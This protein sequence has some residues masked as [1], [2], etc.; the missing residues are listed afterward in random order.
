MTQMLF[1][2]KRCM[3]PKYRKASALYKKTMGG[4]K[5]CNFERWSEF[6]KQAIYPGDDKTVFSQEYWDHPIRKGPKH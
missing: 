3:T 4:P 1:F 6:K 5:K 2:D